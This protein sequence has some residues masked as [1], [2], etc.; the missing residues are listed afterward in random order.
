MSRINIP[1]KI[2]VRY[3]GRARTFDRRAKRD[4]DYEKLPDT[5]WRLVGLILRSKFTPTLR[6]K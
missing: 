3:E 1:L 4:T 6:K 2:R 5:V